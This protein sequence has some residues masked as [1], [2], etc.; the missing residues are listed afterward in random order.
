MYNCLCVPVLAA[1]E[2]G[3]P[4]MTIKS[5]LVSLVSLNGG[6]TFH[7]LL[8]CRKNPDTWNTFCLDFILPFVLGSNKFNYLTD[9]IFVICTPVN[10]V[11]DLSVIK[12]INS[13]SYFSLLLNYLLTFWIPI[14][15]SLWFS[16]I[17]CPHVLMSSST[18]VLKS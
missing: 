7:W 3:I 15:W 10:R 12:T 9:H 5:S 18:N 8:N 6:K 13:Y 17:P 4:K 11:N 16:L 1:K 14:N 2:C